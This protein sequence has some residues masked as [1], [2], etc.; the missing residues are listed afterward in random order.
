MP[1]AEALTRAS[2][3]TASGPGTVSQLVPPSVV[4]SKVMHAEPAHGASPRAQPRLGLTK[5]KLVTCVPARGA[6]PAGVAGDAAGGAVDLAI[7]EDD[8]EDRIAVVVVA[9]TAPVLAQAVKPRQ[10][11]AISKPKRESTPFEVT[12]F[13]LPRRVIGS[14]QRLTS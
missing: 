4:L 7:D 13:R 12:S 10:A 6:A 5:V 8:D 1:D 11:A 9:L 3:K 14:P 2:A